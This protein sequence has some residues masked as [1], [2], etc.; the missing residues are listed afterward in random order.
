MLDGHLEVTIGM[1]TSDIYFIA[2]NIILLQRMTRL[3]SDQVLP[4]HY[5]RE[6]KIIIKCFL[7]YCRAHKEEID[8]LFQM[9]SIFTVRTTVDFS[10]LRDF[11]THEVAEGY[12]PEQKKTILSRFL[13]F[14]KDSSIA[15]DHKVQ[16]FQILITPLLTSAFQKKEGALI[17]DPAV[18]VLPIY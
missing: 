7:N 11:Y 1:I 12:T 16:A 10:F 5:L 4:Q 6:S 9:L 17:L 14:F 2:T 3:Q 18:C 15:Q 13:Q 8:V